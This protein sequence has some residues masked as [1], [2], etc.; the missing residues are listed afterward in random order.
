MTN[1]TPPHGPDPGPGAMR[2]PDTAIRA[3]FDGDEASVR[4]VLDRITDGLSRL[5]LPEELILST[6]IVLAEVF[7]NIV[8]HAYAGHDG[9][10]I[11]VWVLPEPAGISC[12]IRDSGTALPDGALPGET[13]PPIDPDAIDT[14]PEGGFGWAIVRDMTDK[15]SYERRRDENILRLRIS[16]EIA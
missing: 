9:G 3:S 10:G 5:H 12:E 2:L 14:W 15:L 8:E 16:N 1:M 4:E 11:M 7:N 6:R 13:Y